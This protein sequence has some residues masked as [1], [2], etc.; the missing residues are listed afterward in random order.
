MSLRAPCAVLLSLYPAVGLQGDRV[1]SV[2][3]CFEGLPF[4]VHSICTRLHATHRAKVP[5]LHVLTNMCDLPFHPFSLFFF[6]FFWM[7]ATL[8]GEWW[9]LI[10]VLVFVSL[11]T[12]DVQ[13]LSTR[14]CPLTCLPWR[15]VCSGLLAGDEETRGFRGC[16]GLE[17]ENPAPH[18]H[19]RTPGAVGFRAPG[20]R[21]RPQTFQSRGHVH[22]RKGESK[23]HRFPPAARDRRG[24][25]SDFSEW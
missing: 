15:S 7:G 21:R 5:V 18:T 6:S 13:R 3:F 1:D 17:P 11:M 23:C 8:L 20:L 9:R 12:G 19:K 14:F 16:K 10:V 2:L 25:G 24:Q 22:G 4:C